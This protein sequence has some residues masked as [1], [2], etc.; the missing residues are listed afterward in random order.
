MMIL[1]IFTIIAFI[2][3][4]TL[5]VVTMNFKK[6]QISEIDNK[7]LFEFNFNYVFNKSC[8]WGYSAH[9]NISY[10][11]FSTINFVM[12]HNIRCSY[13]CFYFK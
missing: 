12:L 10:V 7:S 2:S 1:E 5:P 6:A 8:Y 3:C 9:W 4:I 13:D 11:D